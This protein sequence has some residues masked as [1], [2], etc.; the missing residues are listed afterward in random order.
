[1]RRAALTALLVLTLCSCGHAV[2]DAPSSRGGPTTGPTHVDPFPKTDTSYD[3]ATR[4]LAYFWRGY[5][6]TEIP[7]QPVLAAVHPVP[8]VNAS[9]GPVSDSEAQALEQG[10][11]RAN[12]LSAWASAHVQPSLGAHLFAEPFV[13]GVLGVALAKGTSVS[14]PS[15]GIYPTKV[16]IYARSPVLQ[17]EIIASG[18]VV[19]SGDM[20]LR[21]DFA[22]PCTITGTTRNGVVEVLDVTPQYSVVVEGSLRADPVLGAV[23]FTDSAIGC[24]GNPMAAAGMCG[25]R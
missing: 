7:G 24:Q 13:L 19:Q 14:V 1:M 9:G 5:D 3:R 12:V 23:F 25:Q 4:A 6:V 10:V 22:G 18:E 15:C 20:P 16:T 8:L 2:S 21:L 11:V 17:A